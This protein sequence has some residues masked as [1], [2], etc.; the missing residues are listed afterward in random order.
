MGWR[1]ITPP[2]GLCGTGSITPPP[3]LCH[4]DLITSPPGLCDTV[5]SDGVSDGIP[6]DTPDWD[7]ICSAIAQGIQQSETEEGM[8]SSF[9]CDSLSI[10]EADE[11]TPILEHKSDFHTSPLQPIRCR[12]LNKLRQQRTPGCAKA[13]KAHLKPEAC[14]KVPVEATSASKVMAVDDS[15]NIEK[16]T[17]LGASYT[18]RWFGLLAACLLVI[19]IAALVICGMSHGETVA[20]ESSNSLAVVAGSSHAW[21]TAAPRAASMA[22][23]LVAPLAKRMDLEVARGRAI[24]SHV[25]TNVEGIQMFWFSKMRTRKSTVGRQDHW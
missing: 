14:I 13:K 19:G 8:S 12:K 2:P 7:A 17:S 25:M 1:P 10:D 23:K 6:N 24:A 15:K 3:G 20:K 11:Q 4:P 22:N 21:A 9:S 16:Q 18:S 5:L